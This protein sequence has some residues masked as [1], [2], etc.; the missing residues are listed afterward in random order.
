M[1][2]YIEP[3]WQGF[4]CDDI[5]IRKPYKRSTVPDSIL[6]LG[7]FIIPFLAVCYLNIIKKIFVFNFR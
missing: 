1:P 6:H 3:H 7:I 4:Y 2:L 5:S